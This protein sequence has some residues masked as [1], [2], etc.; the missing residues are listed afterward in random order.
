MPLLLFTFFIIIPA[1]EIILIVKVG[2]LIG[3]LNTLLLLFGIGAFGAYLAKLQGLKLVQKMQNNLNQGLMPSSEVLDG[4]LI[5][6]AGILL[7]I[8][9]YITDIGGILLLIPWT[10]SLIKILLRK[11]MEAMVKKGQI[12]NINGHQRSF[13]RFDDIDI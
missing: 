5:L 10:R 12:I 11:K 8:P 13:K 7:I 4:F 9:G 1:L 2:S 6:V 3:I